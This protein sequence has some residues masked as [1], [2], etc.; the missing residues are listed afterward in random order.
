MSASND[1]RRE[2]RRRLDAWKAIAQYLGRDVTT[3]RRWEK[4]EGLPVHRH[5]HAKLGSV[6]AFTDEIDA[7][8][9]RRSQSI[10]ARHAPA[11]VTTGA[12]A[13]GRRVAPPNSGGR[14]RGRGLLRLCCGADGSRLIHGRASEPAV[15]LVA[16]PAGV[17]I[18]RS[19]RRT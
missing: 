8:W 9:Q 17:V 7:W 10:R 11:A 16:P 3:V 2:I 13:F 4:R 15:G 6:Y 14:G 5:L 18:N 1:A 19:P 12:S